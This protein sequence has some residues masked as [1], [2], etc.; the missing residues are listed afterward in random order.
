MKVN[1]GPYID[2]NSP[3][4]QRVIDV[5]IDKYDTWNMDETLAHIIVPMLKNLKDTKQGSP[6]VDD[7]DVPDPLKSTS[8]PEKANPWDTDDNFHLRWSW[9]MDEMIWAFEQKLVDWEGQYY[10]EYVEGPEGGIRG[11]YFEWSDDDSRKLHMERM[12]NGYR[13]F[14]KYYSSLWD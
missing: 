6:N 10:G 8:A 14:G 5:K 13:L 7:D 1:I 12:E 2:G 9:V 3:E 11:G 4:S